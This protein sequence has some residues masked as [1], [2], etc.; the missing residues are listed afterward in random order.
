MHPP[1]Q[2]SLSMS[3]TNKSASDLHLHGQTMSDADELRETLTFRLTKKDLTLLD[4]ITKMRGAD[5][6]SF[7]RRAMRKEFAE[8]GFLDE[9]ERKALGL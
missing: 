8:L 2:V 4:R 7:L 1:E 9:E 6:S 3:R 5:P